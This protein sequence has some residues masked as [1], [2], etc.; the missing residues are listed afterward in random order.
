[1]VADPAGRHHEYPV[2]HA[3]G[4]PQRPVACS[5]YPSV[6]LVK[7][8]DHEQDRQ[9]GVFHARVRSL[10]SDARTTVAARSFTRMLL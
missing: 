2:R 4:L 10:A 7:A 3:D 9:S 6:G 1:M 8:V 5:G